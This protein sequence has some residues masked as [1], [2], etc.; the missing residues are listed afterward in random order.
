[1]QDFDVRSSTEIGCRRASCRRCREIVTTDCGLDQSRRQQNGEG[2]LSIQTEHPVV[3]AFE[4]SS[5]RYITH[6]L[7]STLMMFR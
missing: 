3:F 5:A 2:E 7:G 6:N 4:A 1:M